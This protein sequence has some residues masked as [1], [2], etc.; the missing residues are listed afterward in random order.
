[1]SERQQ[2]N[3]GDKKR[4]RPETRKEIQIFLSGN[5]VD[6]ITLKNLSQQNLGEKKSLIRISQVSVSLNRQLRAYENQEI[7]QVT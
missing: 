2:E 1:M 6:Q 3:T 4:N 7:Q 5:G